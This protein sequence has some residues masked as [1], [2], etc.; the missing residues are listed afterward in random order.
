[1]ASEILVIIDSGDDLVPSGNKLLPESVLNFHQWNPLKL[2]SVI[3][4][5]FYHF[6][7]LDKTQNM[8]NYVDCVE[9]ISDNELPI[10]IASISCLDDMT[11]SKFEDLMAF[12]FSNLE[13]A[14]E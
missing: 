14:L 7:V 3:F 2:F 5:Q 4:L 8:L 12:M 13:R 10:P 9:L 11:R 1:M 6:L